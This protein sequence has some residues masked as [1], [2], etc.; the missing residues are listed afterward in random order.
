MKKIEIAAYGVPEE[1]ARC[2]DVHDV[3]TP[4]AREIVFDVTFPI[5]PA[6]RSAAVPT[7]SRQRCRPPR[8]PSASAASA[9]VGS[10]VTDIKPGDL[11]IHMQRENWAQRRRIAAAD[12]IPLPIGL[13][14]KQAAMLRI[15]PATA[16]CLLE[17]HVALKPGDWVIQDVANAA[18]GRQLIV[19]AK[20]KCAHTINVVRRNGSAAHKQ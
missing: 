18:V 1:V 5:N 20:Q 3:G 17:D 10:E 6:C 2:V 16:L 19:L 9:R 7:A 4:G 12:A 13:D 14:L 15:N 11:V 8:V